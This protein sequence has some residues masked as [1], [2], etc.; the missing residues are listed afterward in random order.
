MKEYRC[1]DENGKKNII[2]K[3]QVDEKI[4]FHFC[5]LEFRTFMLR[6]QLLWTFLGIFLITI[7]STLI[8]MNLAGVAHLVLYFP[9]EIPSTF[10]NV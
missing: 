8:L 3:N 10:Q 7:N 5:S 2:D 4:N 1:K 9:L 6:F